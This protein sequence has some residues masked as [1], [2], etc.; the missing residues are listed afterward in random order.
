MQLFRKIKTL[1]FSGIF[2]TLLAIPVEMV[3]AQA[4]SPGGPGAP[5]PGGP[6]GPGSDPGCDP[7]CPFCPK[8]PPQCIPVDGG[9]GFLL[10]AGIGVG[11]WRGRKSRSMGQ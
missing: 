4:P 7:C 6:G 2:I 9:I 10:A 8:C 5:S 3:M 11:I 1:C